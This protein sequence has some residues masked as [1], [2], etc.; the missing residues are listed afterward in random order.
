VSLKGVLIR[1]GQRVILRI[2]AANRDSARFTDANE[3]DI[4]RRGGGHLTLGT[5][6]HSCVG[7]SLIRM[8]F[9][10]V[11]QPL[12][13]RFAAATLCESPAWHGGPVYRWAAPL[14]VRLAIKPFVAGASGCYPS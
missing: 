7:A 3:L 10:A 13:E 14:R 1:K 9:V 2:V 4:G 6:S 12:V 8:S 5:G 11:T